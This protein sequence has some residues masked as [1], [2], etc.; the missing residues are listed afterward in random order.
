M[1]HHVIPSKS[2]LNVPPQI[3]EEHLLTIKNKGWKT[4][5]S[6]ELLYLLS[7]QK[8]SRKKCLAITFDDGFLDNYLY[9]YPILKKYKIKAIL[10]VAT[11][12]ITNLEIKRKGLNFLSHDEIWKIAFTEQKYKVMCTWNELKEMES[13]GIFDIQSHGHSHKI[14]DLIKTKDYKSIREDLELSKTLIRKYLNKTPTQ[15]AWSKGV[16][17]YESINLA[18]ELGFKALYTTQRGVNLNDPFLIKRL[19]VKNKRKG[20]FNK[21]LIIYGSSL[22]INLYNKV[23]FR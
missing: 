15:L 16:Y 21:K 22:F 2:D 8:E 9:T 10:F 1:Y 5:N 19:A 3:F 7:N 12:F 18:R 11:C 20:W 6:N 23:K 4:L 13:E 14:P 17:D